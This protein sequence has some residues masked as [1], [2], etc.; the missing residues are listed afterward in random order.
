[1]DGK[2]RKTISLVVLGVVILQIIITTLKYVQSLHSLNNPLIPKSLI[3]PIRDY[4]IAVIAIY[5][6]AVLA[7]LFYLFKNNFFWGAMIISF[8]ALGI[9]A[10]L[11]HEIQNY[12]FH[13]K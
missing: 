3:M 10:I 2:Q 1:M 12:F 8:L 5:L 11:G 7:N 9:V 6:I 13:I 4:C